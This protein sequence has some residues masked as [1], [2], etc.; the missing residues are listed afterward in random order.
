MTT[1]AGRRL[2]RSDFDT[3]GWGPSMVRR[4]VTEAV[5]AI[6]AEAVAAY[7]TALRAKVEGLSGD[8]L[9]ELEQAWALGPFRAAVLAAIDEAMP[10]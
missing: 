2:L 7:R 10:K 1:E 9:S 4:H 8:P 6:E 5:A 3:T